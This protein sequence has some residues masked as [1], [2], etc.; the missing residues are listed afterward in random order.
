MAKVPVSSKNAT[1]AVL[2]NSIYLSTSGDTLTYLPNTGQ[3]L[4]M[5]NTSG[6]AVTVNIDGAAG[7]VVTIPGTAGTTLNVAP[8]L[9]INIPAYSF[10]YLSLDKAE[11]FLQGVVAITASTGAVIRAVTVSPLS[12]S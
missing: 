7:T 5:F 2:L 8:G 4:W 11:R 12:F 1:T 3:E 10:A 6:N 9:P